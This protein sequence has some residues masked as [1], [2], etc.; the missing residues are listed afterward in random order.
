MIS[1]MTAAARP[2]P[3]W[4]TPLQG[5]SASP[6][7]ASPGFGLPSLTEMRDAQKS[8]KK[9]M[10][11]KKVQSVRERM[12]ALKLMVKIDP[13]AGLKMTAELA[14]ELKSAVKDYVEAGGKN[15]TDG[16]MAMMRRDA[17]DA[18]EAADAALRGLPADPKDADGEAVE[19]EIGAETAKVDA[20]IK[21]AQAAYATAF[22]IADAQDETADRAEAVLGAATTDRGFFQQVKLALA[23]LKEAREKIKADWAHP[24]SPNKDD[25][26]AADK[27]MAELE[28]AIDM[29]PTGMPNPA[30]SGASVKA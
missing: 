7:E 1:L 13:R 24:M 29:A 17:K 5:R 11:A 14:K 9:E 4:R 27:E 2:L 26:K 30:S 12:D 3:I 18:R 20:E 28:K 25:W 19:A 10:A 16:E 22:G 21:R 15:V 6:G 8:M 23:E